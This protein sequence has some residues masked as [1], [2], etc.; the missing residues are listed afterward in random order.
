MLETVYHKADE[1]TV[2][3][4]YAS[5]QQSLAAMDT[6]LGQTLNTRADHPG[7]REGAETCQRPEDVD[8][9]EVSID[10]LRTYSVHPNWKQIISS[11]NDYGQT[12]AHI[13]VTLGY[14]RLLRH[15]FTWEIDLN[16]VDNMGLTAL[17]YAYLF[18]QE[19]CAKFL[20]QS[21]VNQFILDDLGRSPSDLDPSLEVRLRSIMDIDGD[22][23]ADSASPIEY[24]TKM[25]DE[26]GRLYAKHFLVQQWMRR[27]E[28]GGGGE[29][30]PSRY[31][32][33]ENLGRP[34][35]ANNPPAP[36]F[37]DERGRCV[38]YDRLP[39]SDVRIPEENSTLIAATGA[40][41]RLHTPEEMGLE[42]SIEMA[43]PPHVVLPP[44][45]ISKA[46][47]QSR[48]VDRPSGI[49]Q[50]TS[51]HPAPLDGAI[52]TPYL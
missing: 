39:P 17:H 23:H 33:P 5:V 50:D 45:P 37:T 15:L 43:A 31:Q 46:S 12:M 49:G 19:D 13:S 4:T 3:K 52:N 29:V 51:S 18:K 16:V 6:H 28:D 2:Q 35:T 8:L 34:R 44:S 7:D 22:G 9:E 32:S 38:T 11:C 40:R 30:P 27:D 10:F 21:G 41:S 24:D 26:V 42:A 36:D 48:E 20:I 25:P 14:V 1:T 47:A